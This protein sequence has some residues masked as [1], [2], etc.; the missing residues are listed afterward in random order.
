MHHWQLHLHLFLQSLM[1]TLFP[2]RQLKYC[3]NSIFLGQALAAFLAFLPYRNCAHLLHLKYFREDPVP[4]MKCLPTYLNYYYTIRLV[5]SSRSHLYCHHRI[6]R[7]WTTAFLLPLPLHPL[8]LFCR[9]LLLHQQFPK[10][11]ATALYDQ[12]FVP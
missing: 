7:Q 12:P 10:Y 2:H 4:D 5:K 11:C 8:P 1:Q 9:I 6:P 3:N